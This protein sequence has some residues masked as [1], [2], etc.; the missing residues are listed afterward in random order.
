VMMDDVQILSRA[1]SAAEV[2]L[3]RRAAART[4]QPRL[5]TP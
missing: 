1:I 4:D 2:R 5:P 3:D